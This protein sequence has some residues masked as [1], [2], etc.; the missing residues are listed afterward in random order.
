MKTSEERL[1]GERIRAV[2]RGVQEKPGEKSGEETVQTCARSPYC[3][4]AARPI[5]IQLGG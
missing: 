3:K 1:S 4:G 2:L 5:F